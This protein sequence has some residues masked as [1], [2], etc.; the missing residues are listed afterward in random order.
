MLLTFADFLNEGLYEAAHPSQLNLVENT[1]EMTEQL[2]DWARAKTRISI[3]PNLNSKGEVTVHSGSL[4][5]KLASVSMVT[6]ECDS[7]VV[8]PS[9][10]SLAQ[11]QGEKTVHAAFIGKVHPTVI[12]PQK[13][14]EA[15]TY[16]PHKGDT[17]FS[18][19]GKPY[20]GGGLITMVGW[21]A[22]RVD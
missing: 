15:V 12:I 6:I 17:E 14:D 4:G 16:N 5:G 21:K 3:R 20:Q 8:R 22:F 11:S 19:K 1:P 2:V 13:G 10:Q 9:G 7:T 18:W